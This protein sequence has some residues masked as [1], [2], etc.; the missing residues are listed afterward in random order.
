M[1]QKL[2]TAIGAVNCAMG[3]TAAARYSSPSSSA[4]IC[5]MRHDILDFVLEGAAMYSM[6]CGSFNS[7][8]PDCRALSLKLLKTSN[9]YGFQPPKVTKAVADP[10][11]N[12]IFFGVIRTSLKSPKST[13]QSASRGLK[14]S[15]FAPEPLSNSL[16]LMMSFVEIQWNITTTSC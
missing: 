14:M 3:S 5:H 6:F 13:C 2:F 15:P 11:R 8:K 12:L 7:L 9:R 10:A 4:R 1:A 16:P